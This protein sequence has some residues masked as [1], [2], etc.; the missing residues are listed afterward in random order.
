MSGPYYPW[1]DGKELGPTGGREPERSADQHRRLLIEDPSTGELI[2]ECHVPSE[3]DLDTA[4][5]VAHAA[6]QSR[7]W[8]RMECSQRAD[9]LDKCALLLTDA[10]PELIN[11]ESRQTGRV[12]REMKTQLPSLVRWFKY[13]AA[14][15]RVDE[16][17]VLPTTGKLHNFTSRVPLGVVVLITSFNH[18][19]LIAT[20]KLAPALAAGN[21]VILKPSELTPLTSILLGKILHRAGVPAGVFNVLPGTGS[22]VGPALVSHPLVRKVDVT[23][24]TEMGR[25]IGAIAGGKLCPFTAELGGKAPLLVFADANVQ[26]AVN[27]IAFGSYIASG[28]TCVASTR[29]IVDNTIM[30]NLLQALK[31][32]VDGITA[33]MG[34][35][36]HPQSMMG[37]LISRKQLAKVDRYVAEA[38]ENFAVRPLVG[39]KR[40]Q[41]RSALDGFDFSRGYFYEPTVL[42]SR[43]GQITNMPIWRRELF[44]PVIVVVGFDTEDEA[45]ALANDT[46]FGLGAG[47]WTTD[48]A[49]AFR[50]SEKIEAG[51]VWVN[52]HHRNDPSSPWGGAKPASGV[53]SENGI[54]AYHA[55]TTT[56]STVV[57]FAP[58]QES[59]DMDDW[60]GEASQ[61]VRY[62]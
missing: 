11:L 32:K 6:F 19:L 47:I 57:N 39:G 58:Y 48:L 59:L 43:D 54:D 36:I 45:L 17:S 21:S 44:G 41:G 25:A 15:L 42:V 10:L 62:G 27:G 31:T 24:G 38:L 46:E 33:R 18:P 1:V 50:V 29:I 13:Y 28:Q 12:I 56:K 7:V 34:A 8:S 53:G 40:L 37:P 35:P 55:Y 49:R 14:L 30:D 22:S 20:K 16:Q 5:R 2:A 23:G 60:F 4:V 52:T 51:I 26:A 9:V 61:N 3:D